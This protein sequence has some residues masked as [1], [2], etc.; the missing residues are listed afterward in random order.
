MST[1][2]VNTIQ[3]TSGGSSSTP[4]QI[5]SGR[6]KSFVTFNSRSSTSILHSF[7][8]SSVTDNGTGDHNVNFA[9]A[10]SDADYAI[11][12]TAVTSSGNENSV[13]KVGPRASTNTTNL[14]LTKTT[15]QVRIRVG[16]GTTEMDAGNVYMVTYD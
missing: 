3:N 7:N 15:T 1:L 6:A 4:E 14:P 11:A 10:H 9:T 8:V 12:G 13:V 5:E 2:K 16:A